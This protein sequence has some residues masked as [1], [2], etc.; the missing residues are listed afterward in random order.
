[1]LWITHFVKSF[2][3]PIVTGVPVEPNVIKMT[4][5]SNDEKNSFKRFTRA[6]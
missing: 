5:N 3:V 2:S 1:M 4:I 6:D